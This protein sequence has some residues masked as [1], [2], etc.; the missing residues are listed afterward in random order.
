MRIRTPEP[1]R[2]SNVENTRALDPALLRQHVPEEMIDWDRDGRGPPIA[3]VIANRYHAIHKA[4]ARSRLRLV[5]SAIAVAVRHLY[6][7]PRFA[8]GA[9]RHAKNEMKE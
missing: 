5:H 7:T 9:G 6:V 3:G 4:A 1:T 2:F 8:C